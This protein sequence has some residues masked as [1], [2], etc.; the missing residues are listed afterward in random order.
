[1]WILFYKGS[2]SFVPGICLWLHFACIGQYCCQYFPFLLGFLCVLA[3][4]LH[5]CFFLTKWEFLL[6]EEMK[7]VTHNNFIL[8]F[9]DSY[10][11]IF[12]IIWFYHLCP[13]SENLL[14]MVF[15]GVSFFSR[16]CRWA[17]QQWF[18]TRGGPASAVFWGRACLGL[19]LEIRIHLV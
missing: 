8:D 9:L 11:A 17:L 15:L 7:I 16:I 5:I 10:G 6:I 1:M 14:R 18:W 19:I 2:C 13:C 12:H 3:N 4:V